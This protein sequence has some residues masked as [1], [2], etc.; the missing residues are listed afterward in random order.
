MYLIAIGIIS[1]MVLIRGG[2][3]GEDLTSFLLKGACQP[4]TETR[5]L[6]FANLTIS[7]GIKAISIPMFVR[8]KCGA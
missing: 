5:P 3:G 1:A 4:Y 7:F 8:L 6:S 2:L